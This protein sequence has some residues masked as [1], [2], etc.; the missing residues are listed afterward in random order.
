MMDNAAAGRPFLPRDQA[1]SRRTLLY[2]FGVF[3]CDMNSPDLSSR[4]VQC[5]SP[6]TLV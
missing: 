4:F 5:S 3:F 1:G 6:M 2:F